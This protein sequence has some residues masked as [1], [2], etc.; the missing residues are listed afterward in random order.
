MIDSARPSLDRPPPRMTEPENNLLGKAGKEPGASLALPPSGKARRASFL[1]V[2]DNEDNPAKTALGRAPATAHRGG[3]ASPP[4]RKAAGTAAEAGSL[5]KP[6][7]EFGA[8]DAGSDASGDDAH[9]SDAGSEAALAASKVV[10][11]SHRC[12]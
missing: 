2:D 7:L 6:T 4:M 3:R 5:T 1:I 9:S 11:E 8:L 10:A 12:V